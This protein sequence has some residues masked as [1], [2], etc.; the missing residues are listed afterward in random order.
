MPLGRFLNVTYS[1]LSFE[2]KLNLRFVYPRRR[3]SNPNS[4]NRIVYFVGIKESVTK[5]CRTKTMNTK[6]QNGASDDAQL[7][8]SEAR[9]KGEINQTDQKPEVKQEPIVKKQA[10]E[11]KPPPPPP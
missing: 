4:Q 8:K 9:Q 1:L 11:T 6:A 5:A 7:E 10:V 2:E 3:P